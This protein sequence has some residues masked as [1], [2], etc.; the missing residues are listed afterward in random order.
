MELSLGQ[1]KS[2]SG[3]GFIFNIDGFFSMVASEVWGGAVGVLGNHQTS[4]SLWH[5]LSSVTSSSS[6]SSPE[7][8]GRHFEL[9]TSAVVSL[10]PSF[11]FHRSR[12][13]TTAVLYLL[14]RAQNEIDRYLKITQFQGSSGFGSVRKEHMESNT[15]IQSTSESKKKSDDRGGIDRRTAEVGP[16]T[17]KK[18]KKKN[19][20]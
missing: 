6:S 13:C 3:D 19:D 8:S 10:N 16:L 17:L 12:G 4:L 2:A 18:K 20:L 15:C 5:K 11:F 7:S 1:M 14:A 9:Q